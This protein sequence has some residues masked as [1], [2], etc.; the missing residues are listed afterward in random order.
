MTIYLDENYFARPDHNVLG[1][2][3]ETDSRSI[4][5]QGLETDGADSYSIVI[6]YDDGVKYELDITDGTLTVGGSLL[7]SA[8]TVSCQ[9][10]AKAAVEGTNAYRYVKKSNIFPLDIL[11]SIEGEPA[12]VPSYEQSLSLLD[13]IRKT[14]NSGG[15]T[16]SDVKNIITSRLITALSA[17]IQESEV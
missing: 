10:L 9:I 8:Q 16:R 11:D 4:Y 15:V 3:G 13:V 1:Y 17:D 6:C 14:I 5:I 2:V 7:R 12:P